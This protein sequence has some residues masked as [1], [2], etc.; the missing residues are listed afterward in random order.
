MPRK[1]NNLDKKMLRVGASMLRQKG[2]AALSVREVAKKAGVNLGMFNYHFNDKNE[3]I[4]MILEDAYSTFITELRDNQA[5]NLEEVLFS[6]AKFSR[7][8]HQSVL[9]LIGDVLSGEKNV[10]QFLRKNFTTHFTILFEVLTKHFEEKNYNPKYLE[11]AFRYL[12]SSVGLPNLL[13]GLKIKMNPKLK[14]ELDSDSCLRRRVR[15]AMNGLEF[16]CKD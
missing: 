15:A 11:H 16:I 7:N 1:S 4:K 2:A 8:H 12:I 3:F 5:Q 6:M 10:A 13:V 9:S 14:Q